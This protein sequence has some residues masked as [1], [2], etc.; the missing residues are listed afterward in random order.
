M[1][2]TVK[3]TCNI[4]KAGWLSNEIVRN[5]PQTSQIS[6]WISKSSSYAQQA[7]HFS[8]VWNLLVPL[9]WSVLLVLP[10]CAANCKIERN[11][12]SLC[13]GVFGFTEC[14]ESCLDGCNTNKACHCDGT[15][16]ENFVLD[17]DTSFCFRKYKRVLLANRSA[18]SD[19]YS[20]VM[21]RRFCSCSTS[22]LGDGDVDILGTKS[23]QTL[24]Y[25]WNPGQP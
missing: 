7:D 14:D 13:C 22:V 10:V 5:F 20:Y 21:Q 6:S 4:I 8:T 23:I 15:C 17:T 16:D 9:P 3:H 12:K 1:K 11:I 19:I 25:T 24:I 2:T 18:D